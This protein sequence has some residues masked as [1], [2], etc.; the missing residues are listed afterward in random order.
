MKILNWVNIICAS[1][2]SIVLKRNLNKT[3]LHHSDVKVYDWLKHFIA[4]RPVF[5]GILVVVQISVTVSQP[6]DRFLQAV[7]H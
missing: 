7:T 2:L 5:F 4:Q 6:S 1:K 3:F